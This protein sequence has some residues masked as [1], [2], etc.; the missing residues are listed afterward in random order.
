[1]LLSSKVREVSC[2]PEISA[3]DLYFLTEIFRSY[4]WEKGHSEVQRANVNTNFSFAFWVLV[5]GYILSF[6]NMSEQGKKQKAVCMD[7][8]GKILVYWMKGRAEKPVIGIVELHGDGFEEILH[9]QSLCQKALLAG[10]VHLALPD[11]WFFS[12]S[13]RGG[14]N[15]YWFRY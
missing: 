3:A 4:L 8:Q 11:C 9:S 15:K 7:P 14:R 12:S 10:A 1:M 2:H 6:W 13:R 5:V